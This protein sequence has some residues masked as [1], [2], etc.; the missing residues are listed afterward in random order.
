MTISAKTFNIQNLTH[1]SPPG[2]RAEGREVLLDD[3]SQWGLSICKLSDPKPCHRN[4]ESKNSET[5]TL[6]PTL[7]W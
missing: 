4:P 7:Q 6:G 1:F 5:N 3:R 2:Q